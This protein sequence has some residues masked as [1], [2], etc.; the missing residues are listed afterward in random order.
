[1]SRRSAP[2]QPSA[3][4]LLLEIGT[5]ELPP[6]AV[7]P[8]LEQLQRDTAAALAEAR[9]DVKRVQ[10]TGTLRR[11]ALMADGLDSR[12]RDLVGQVRGP[13]ARIAY[14]AGGQPTQAAHGFARSQG[15]LVE[16]LRVREIEGGQYVVAE[17][18][19]PGR[20]AA[21]VLGDLLPRLAAGLA[22]PKMMRWNAGGFRFG[23]PIRWIVA[24]LDGRVIPLEIAGL[25]AGRRTFG[26]RF[27]TPG[28]ITVPGAAAY[29]D[30][31]KQAQVLLSEEGRRARIAEGAVAL[32]GAMGGRPVL[33]P[34]LLDELVWSTEHPTPVLGTF[35]PALVAAL[36]SVVVLVTLQ[37]HQKCFGIVDGSGAL[38]P[39][40]VTVRDG[41]NSHLDTVR[42]GHEWVV[43]ARLQDALFFLEEDRRGGFE[44]WNEALARIAHI[45]GLGTVA[46]HVARV[47]RLAG[48]LAGAAGITELDRRTL[49]RAAELCKADLTTSLVREFPE[50]QGT[51]G[52]IYARERGETAG[53]GAAIEE[54]YGPRAAA[55]ADL[56]RSIPG[57]L[58]SVADRAVLLAGAVLAGLEPS[59]SQDPH[60]LRRA[61]AG[62]A[63][64]LREGGLTISLRQLLGQAALTFDAPDEA[65]AQAADTCL[66][67]VRQR[68]QGMLADDGIAYDTINAVAAVDADDV[69]DLV[70]RARA[71]HEFRAQPAMSLLATG[72][73]R[74]HRILVQAGQTAD[75]EYAGE[76]A[77]REFREELLAEP[78]E[79]ELH[80][81]WLRVHPRLTEA[82]ESKLYALALEEI[83]A[84]AGPIDGFFDKVL[85]NAPDPVLRENRLALLER[86]SGSF[87]RIA[88]FSVLVI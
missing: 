74:V 19:E 68:L 87:K 6:A 84:L 58:L 62:V 32:A 27:L 56:P 16:S 79:V 70:A 61:A 22:F 14:D 38:M 66:R 8:A 30:V 71:L 60:G 44:Q 72:Y 9:L 85:V 57:A 29:E 1:M 88:D 48:W 36:P 80:G 43:R 78:A 52:G 64:V 3:A 31:V 82:A 12:Q 11:L 15:V 25:R 23:R 77:P 21:E 13:A 67:I 20:P 28:S 35:E 51:I 55:G 34:T 17:V 18:R 76:Q 53:V 40:F 46:D 47:R 7:R 63:A 39:A 65:R 75:G 73:L 86:V 42:T 41:G 45:A 4:R 83:A 24:L 59:G 26:H 37:H 5:E 81:A 69:P 2:A 49:N 54:H 33:D 10:T 50:L